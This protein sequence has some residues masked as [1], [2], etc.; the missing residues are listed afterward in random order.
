LLRSLK[1]DF[2]TIADFR[3]ANRTAFKKVFLE[4]VILCRRLNLFGR[5]LLAVDGTRIKAVNNVV[6]VAEVDGKLAEVKAAADSLNLKIA[7]VMGL[8]SLL[9]KNGG[10]G[11]AQLAWRISQVMKTPEIGASRSEILA[12]EVQWAAKFD[13]LTA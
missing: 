1:P 3:S 10:H 4:F 9:H 12:A 2:K 6:L 11:F 5:E 8:H 7:A 13:G